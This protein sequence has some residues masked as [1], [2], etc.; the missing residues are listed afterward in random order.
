[1]KL[2]FYTLI[3]AIEMSLRIFIRILNVYVDIRSSDEI[4]VIAECKFVQFM[5]MRD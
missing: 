4:V 3:S 1:M 5:V 2:G